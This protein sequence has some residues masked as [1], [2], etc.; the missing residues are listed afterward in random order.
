MWMRRS[1]QDFSDE[2]RA[3][4]DIETDRLVAGG[5][6]EAAARAAARRAFGNVTQTQERFYESNRV[7]WFDDL[8]RDVAYA[9]RTMSKRPAFTVMAIL[10]L[11]LGIGANT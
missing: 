4:I 11:S 6:S 10:T 9:L 2:I 8:R 3:N 5:M 1:D 7:R